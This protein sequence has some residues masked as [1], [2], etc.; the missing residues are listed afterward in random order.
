MFMFYGCTN[1]GH[2]EH[3]MEPL[4]GATVPDPHTT[5]SSERVH[6]SEN[7]PGLHGAHESPLGL[8]AV[9]GAHKNVGAEVVISTLGINDETRQNANSQRHPRGAAR[10]HTRFRGY[11]EER[12]PVLDRELTHK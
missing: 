3:E 2:L 7:L 6:V 10:L 4:C 1:R 8:R 11:G 9:P 12:T 5:H